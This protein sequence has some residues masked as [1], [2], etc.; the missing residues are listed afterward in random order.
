MLVYGRDAQIIKTNGI[1]RT[2]TADNRYQN[3]DSD[4]RGV[5]KSDNLSVGPANKRNIYPITTPSEGG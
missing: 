2:N 3:P 5:W 1:Q 4:P